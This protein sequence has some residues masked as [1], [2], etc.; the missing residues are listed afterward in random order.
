MR[1]IG[2]TL[3]ALVLSVGI[4]AAA[5]PLPTGEWLVAD[6]VAKIKIDTCGDRL[7]GVVSWE[8]EPG[9][10]SNNPDPAKRTRPTLG[11][12]ILLGMKA[13]QP[14]RWDGEIYNAEN[15][16]TYSANISLASADV[17]R[18]QGCVLGFL[19]GGQDWSRVKPEPGA[20]APPRQAAAPRPS[21]ASQG[22]APAGR[23]GAKDPTQDVCSLVADSSGTPHE[24]RLK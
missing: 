23:P 24:R 7:W 17:L 1:H 10:D 2:L 19:C 3:G 18:V 15:G 4:A 20:K 16:K 9:I 6:G 13:A 21:G 22:A 8:K 12:P 14:N 5:D 11:M